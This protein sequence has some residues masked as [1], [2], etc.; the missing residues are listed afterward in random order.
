MY[1][2]AA[3]P[4]ELCRVEGSSSTRPQIAYGNVVGKSFLKPVRCFRIYVITGTRWQRWAG[5]DSP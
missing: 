4:A 3:S 2:G 1:V 5:I